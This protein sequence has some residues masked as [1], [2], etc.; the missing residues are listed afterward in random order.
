M[1]LMNLL[2]D[3]SHVIL[4]VAVAAIMPDRP[5]LSAACFGLAALTGLWMARNAVRREYIL[6]RKASE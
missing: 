5:L 2:H 3:A 4:W 1:T 6:R